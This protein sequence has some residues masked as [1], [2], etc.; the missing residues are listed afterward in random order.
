M[1]SPTSQSAAASAR[2]RRAAYGA[3]EAPVMPR[4]T[5]KPLFCPLGGLEENRELAEVCFTEVG[6]RRHRRALVDA[7]WALEM[8]DLES[9]ALVFRPLGGQVRRPEQRAADA[10]VGV[11]VQTARGREELGAGNGLRR[12][13]LGLDP[14]GHLCQ[15]LG[16]QGLLRCCAL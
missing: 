4:K 10:V 3:P 2:T 16:A 5:R 8:L 15:E 9:D 11:A 6:E 14:V 13:V 12:K 7:A 1:Q